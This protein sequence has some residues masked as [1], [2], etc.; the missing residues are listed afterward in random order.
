[1]Y[2]SE[3][4]CDEALVSTS[5][6]TTVSI[7]SWSDGTVVQGTSYCYAVEPIAA[8]GSCDGDRRTV[9]AGCPAPVPAEIVDL[10]VWRQDEDVVLTWTESEGAVDYDI[11]RSTDPDPR[12]WGAP[13][14][15][16]VTDQDPVI[17]GVQWIDTGVVGY[18]ADLFFYNVTASPE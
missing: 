10:G 8:H 14:K 9:V 6:V 17:P 4:S 16:A 18:P 13:W 12:T 15:S 3:V 1:M 7:S 5:P 2:R 11:L